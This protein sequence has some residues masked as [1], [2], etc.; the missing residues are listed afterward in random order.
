MSISLAFIGENVF[1]A[2][3]SNTLEELFKNAHN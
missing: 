3:I 1:K 2:E